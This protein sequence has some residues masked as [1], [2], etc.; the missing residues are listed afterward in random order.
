M[1]GTEKL[2]HTTR[3]TQLRTTTSRTLFQDLE[4]IRR[5]DVGPAADDDELLRV[6]LEAVSFE[7]TISTPWP[8]VSSAPE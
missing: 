7:L 8:F 2:P 1:V 3:T 4:F 5:H 6:E